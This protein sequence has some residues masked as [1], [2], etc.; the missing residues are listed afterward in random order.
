MGSMTIPTRTLMANSSINNGQKGS[1]KW[2]QS[3]AERGLGQEKNACSSRVRPRSWIAGRD[4]AKKARTVLTALVHQGVGVL[5]RT[6]VT[7]WVAVAM[8]EHIWKK[9]PAS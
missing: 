3:G 7:N 4:C 8:V 5:S 9:I 1:E 2:R 6:V